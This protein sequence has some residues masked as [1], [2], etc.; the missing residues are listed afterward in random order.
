MQ[1]GEAVGSSPGPSPGPSPGQPVGQ[2][3]VLLDVIHQGAPH[4]LHHLEDALKVVELQGSL[5]RRTGQVAHSINCCVSI[6]LSLIRKIPWRR[7]WQPTPVF[8]PGEFHIPWTEEPGRLQS[9]G[10]QRARH[11]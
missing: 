11:D 5:R 3:E 6:P 8:L 7:K 2:E 1:E 10:L 4:F 9:M